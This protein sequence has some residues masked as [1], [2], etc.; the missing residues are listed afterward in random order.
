MFQVPP[1]CQFHF[2]FA[3]RGTVG[4]YCYKNWKYIRFFLFQT[5][6]TGTTYSTIWHF[7]RRSRWWNRRHI[8]TYTI[9]IIYYRKKK[10][11]F[12]LLKKWHRKF[13]RV[14]IHFFSMKFPKLQLFF[15]CLYENL[16]LIDRFEGSRNLLSRETVFNTITV[17]VSFVNFS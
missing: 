4:A 15:C 8:S 6:T 12:F 16:H 10:I 2:F 1:F 14:W 3:K 13:L 9:S 17:F 11:H 7:R 5:M